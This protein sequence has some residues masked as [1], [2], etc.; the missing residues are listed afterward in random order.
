MIALPAKEVDRTVPVALYYQLAELLEKEIR[1]G[2]WEPGG[3]LPSEPAMCDHFGVSR[4]TV[5]QALAR[6]ER[7][8]LVTRRAGRGTFVHQQEPG[9]WLLQQSEGLFQIE[10]DRLGRTVTSNILRA[11][12]ATLPKW[13]SEALN[14]PSGS[15]GATLERLRFLDD[16]V[17]LYVVNHVPA[18][19]ART[20]L[21]TENASES[22]YR[23]LEEQEG[24]V[25]FGG[26]RILDAVSTDARTAELLELEQGSPVVFIESVTWD[27]DQ[28][29][30]D[31]YRAW[32]RTDRLRIEIEVGLGSNET[33]LNE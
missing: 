23:R 22:L 6:L 1:G 16:R 32:L 2:T 31:C 25:P 33:E 5:R 19:F 29:P 15:E 14:V 28:K 11:E 30:F 24:L 13:A 8:G 12:L 7:R 27:S 20:A 17:A 3:R 9:L 10:V 4:A 21:T 26:R 18:P